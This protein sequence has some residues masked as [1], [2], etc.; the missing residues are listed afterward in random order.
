MPAKNTV[1]VG[2]DY[3]KYMACAVCGKVF[4]VEKVTVGAMLVGHH[5]TSVAFAEQRRAWRAECDCGEFS[6]FSLLNL[7]GELETRFKREGRQP[8]EVQ[9]RHE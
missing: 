2:I 3:S 8:K 7:I 1:D 9:E 4:Y 6:G 5:E